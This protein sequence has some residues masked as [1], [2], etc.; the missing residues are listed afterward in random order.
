ME[1]KWWR[2]TPFET[3]GSHVAWYTTSFGSA[4]VVGRL[5]STQWFELTLIHI[6]IGGFVIGLSLLALREVLIKTVYH[7][8]RHVL[9]SRIPHRSRTMR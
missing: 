1:R 4:V 9:R 3:K 5:T 2:L 8:G 7:R 6:I